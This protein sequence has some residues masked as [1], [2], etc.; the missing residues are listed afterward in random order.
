MVGFNIE[1]KS[2]KHYQRHRALN[3]IMGVP[4]YA[5][6]EAVVFDDAVLADKGR[7]YYAPI[8]MAMFLVREMLPAKMPYEIGVPIRF[9]E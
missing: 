3:R 1:V 7:I 4:D 5:I 6:S 2:G 8:Y 9:P